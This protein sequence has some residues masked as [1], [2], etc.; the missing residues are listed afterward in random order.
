MV[1]LGAGDGRTPRL[2]GQ[3]LLLLLVPSPGP[4]GCGEDGGSR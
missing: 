3:G 1:L 4:R 2:M